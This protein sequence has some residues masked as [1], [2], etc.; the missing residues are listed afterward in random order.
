MIKF[1]KKILEQCSVA[2]L[3]DQHKAINEGELQGSLQ[4]PS[5]QRWPGGRNSGESPPPH[6][7]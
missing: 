5:L 6:D 3:Y 1:V 4:L 2:K 7:L